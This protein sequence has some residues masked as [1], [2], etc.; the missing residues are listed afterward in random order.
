M[1]N[2]IL[3]M[4]PPHVQQEI[5]NVYKQA[6]QSNNPEQFLAQKFGNAPYYQKAMDVYKSK[7]PDELNTYLGNIYKSMKG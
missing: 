6:M 3:N 5:N 1:M 4:L 2:N 7:S